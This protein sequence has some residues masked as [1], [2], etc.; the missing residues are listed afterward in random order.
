MPIISSRDEQVAQLASQYLHQLTDDPA[1]ARSMAENDLRVRARPQSRAKSAQRSVRHHSQ[2]ISFPSLE[3][4]KAALE[5]H[6]GAVAANKVARDGVHLADWKVLVC[7]TNLWMEYREDAKL[8]AEFWKHYPSAVRS[9]GS[10]GDLLSFLKAIH[11]RLSESLRTHRADALEHLIGIAPDKR[12]GLIKEVGGVR[13]IARLRS[14]KVIGARK[15]ARAGSDDAFGKPQDAGATVP[16]VP[17][18]RPLEAHVD[19][20]LSADPAEWAAVS[21]H[22]VR[23]LLNLLSKRFEFVPPPKQPLRRSNSRPV[24]VIDEPVTQ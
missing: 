20:L 5:A 13:A 9:Q 22:K 11:P 14:G 6:E 21:L 19:E 8:Q 18:Q 1:I 15:A 23:K 4:L 17:G 7:E 10:R 16:V 24:M 3:T 12:L 2:T